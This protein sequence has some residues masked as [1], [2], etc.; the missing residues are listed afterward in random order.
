M[1]RRACAIVVPINGF[2]W[3][4]CAD[5]SPVHSF[6]P[7]HRCWL[8]V[9]AAGAGR[10]GDL[11]HSRRTGNLAVVRQCRWSTPPSC[12]TCSSN[13][14][15]RFLTG[16]AD[17]GVRHARGV[18]AADRPRWLPRSARWRCWTWPSATRRLRRASDLGPHRNRRIRRRFSADG[19]LKY[20]VDFEKDVHWLRWLEAPLSKVGARGNGRAGAGAGGAGDHRLFHSAVEVVQIPRR[21]HL[22]LGL[23]HRRRWHRRRVRRLRPVPKLAAKSGAAG[24]L[25]GAGRCVVQFRR[26]DRRVCA[27]PTISFH[28]RRRSRHRCDVRALDD[29]YLVDRGTLAEYRYLEHGA[30]WAIGVLAAIMLLSAIVAVPEAW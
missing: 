19:V 22:G 1:N 17:R 8:A 2:Q 20:F 26:R 7:W 27:C 28:H 5:I 12:V 29:I 11:R 6:S 15:S 16:D 30:F 18:S 25:S 3:K 14:V 4:R 23:L 21:R 9:M 10:G 13:G 24:F